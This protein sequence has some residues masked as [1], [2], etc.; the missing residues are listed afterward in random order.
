MKKLIPLVIVVLLTGCWDVKELTEIGIVTAMAIDKDEDSGE[1]MLTAQ[2]L[3]PSAEST[4][5]PSQGEPYLII[6]VTGRSISEMLRKTSHKLDRDGF[7]A[8]NKVVIVS[9]EVAKE[10]LLPLFETFQREQLVR[11]YVWLGVTKNTTAKSV[12]EKQKNSISKIS[13]D[14]L[15]SL[16]ENAEHETVSFNLLKL[17]KQSLRQGQN[18]VL[19]VVTFDQSESE[20]VDVHLSGGAA[21]NKDKLVGYMSEIETMAY[22]WIVPTNDNN[23]E[24]TFTF[25]YKEDNYVTLKVID[26]H[27]N[28]KPKVINE[29]DIS[30]TIEIKQKVKITEQQEL[31]K[32]ETRKE[33]VEVVEKF[34]KQTEKEIEAHVGK[35]IAKAQEE[36]QSDIFGFGASLRNRYPKVWNKI[37]DNWNQEF[38]EASYEVKAEVEI[39]NSGLLQGSLHPNE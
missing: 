16:F 11:S 14:F 33:I 20:E 30:F 24:G 13:A 18:P 38:A 25:P 21:F 34:E 3:R 12:L 32:T 23:Q 29:R 27:S 4:F 35:V 6:S 22:N 15:S 37:R 10:G 5:A 1:Y 26:V 7:Y 36:F 9:E 28:I 8:H 17:Y 39:L 19:G 31:K 2:Y